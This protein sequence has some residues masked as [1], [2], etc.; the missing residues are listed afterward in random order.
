MNQNLVENEIPASGIKGLKENW[1]QDLSAGFMV[2]LLALPLSLGIAKASGFP[3]AMGVL[4]AIIG[5]IA[6]TFFNVSPLSIKGPAAGLITIC[7]GSVMEFGGGEQGW[8]TTCAIIMVVGVFQAAFGF[9]K[10]GSLSDFFPNTA[11]HGMLAAIGLIIILKHIPIL[12]GDEPSRYAGEG[13][14]ELLLNIPSFITH[15][16]WHIAVVGLIGLVIMFVL[17]TL[18]IKFFKQ[19]PAPMIVLALTVPL[20]FFWHFRETEGAYSVVSIGD[21]W[22]SFG[23][24]FDFTAIGSFAFWKY[25]FMFLF[26]NSLE[27]LLTVKAVD[28][29]DTTPRKANPNGDLIGVGAG[30]FLSG[31][32]GGLPMISEVVRSSANVGFGARTKWAN[33]FHGFFLLLAMILLIPFIEMIPNAALAAMLIFAGYRL[34]SPKEFIYTFHVGKE[35]FATFL[36]TIIVTLAEDLLMGI[37]AGVALEF[38][39]YIFKG[40]SLRNAF[41]AI[42][43]ATNDNGKITLEIMGA[44]QFTNLIGFK[45]ILEQTPEKAH[46]VLNFD[47]ATLVDHSFMS[48]ITYFKSEFESRG[49]QVEFIGLEGLKPLSHHE[50][51]TRVQKA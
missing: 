46:L 43:Q 16:H 48:F 34:A 10:L 28:Q 8:Q 1:R 44:A 32:V 4:T 41:K 40:T 5:G 15:S 30:N 47:K 13:P 24:H 26:I 51:S 49:G 39:F 38:T 23:W 42:Y 50:L 14:I 36:V 45:R 19:V 11:V 18:K 7:A 27:S 6:T 21:F 33:F 3:V 25:V 35:Q 2:F 17:P 12:L 9:L 20:A 37:A 31:L 22:G 29:L